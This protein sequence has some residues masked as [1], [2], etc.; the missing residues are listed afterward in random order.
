MTMARGCAPNMFLAF[1]AFGLAARL[2][3]AAPA[4]GVVTRCANPAPN[5]NGFSVNDYVGLS[6]GLSRATMC[7]APPKIGQATS[8]AVS[9]ECS[10]C[11]F[12]HSIASPVRSTS[13]TF[14]ASHQL[15]T[16][17]FFQQVVRHSS[18]HPL[19][20]ES[21]LCC[22]ASLALASFPLLPDL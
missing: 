12:R 4:G 21:F 19:L 16:P 13:F 14:H 1:L 7:N 22:C 10:A 15:S 5:T 11:F 17:R 20:A 2:T 9:V 18:Y 6:G 3:F 8:C